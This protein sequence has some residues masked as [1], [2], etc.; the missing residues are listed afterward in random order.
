MDCS[1]CLEPIKEEQPKK[2]L[3]SCCHEFH[4][5][6]LN[7]WLRTNATCPN[8]R[9]SIPI[10]QTSLSQEQREREL[11]EL[12]RLYLTFVLFNW[13]LGTFSGIQFRR[14]FREIHWFVS[15]LHWN[16]LRPISFTMTPRNQMSLTS[17]KTLRGYCIDREQTLFSQMHPEEVHRPIHRNPRTLQMYQEL[18]PQLVEFLQSLS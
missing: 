3:D 16:T 17:I 13:I 4:E 14:H 6:C 10:A 8:C 12:D 9:E 18:K 7:P 2:K 1:I 15:H 5:D 11:R